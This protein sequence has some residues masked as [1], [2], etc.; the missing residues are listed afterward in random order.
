MWGQR[1]KNLYSNCQK[2]AE[3]L[4][5]TVLTNGVWIWAIRIVMWICWRF[6]VHFVYQRTNWACFSINA[7]ILTS[8][9]GSAR[10]VSTQQKRWCWNIQIIPTTSFQ[11]S[12]DSLVALIFTESSRQ[13]KAVL[14]QNG[15]TSTLQMQHKMTQI[16]HNHHFVKYQRKSK[17]FIEKQP[18]RCRIPT[19]ATPF[20]YE[21]DTC[22]VKNCTFFRNNSLYLQH[23]GNNRNHAKDRISPDH[24]RGV[25]TH[26]RYYL[27][28]CHDTWV[29]DVSW[30]SLE[31]SL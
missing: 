19:N 22:T 29:Q 23:E 8:E 12:V 10:Y 4:S 9:Y 28:I 26:I 17:I 15:E 16:E 21:C 7:C 6:L 31:G 24:H 20:W 13:K 1:R 14:L 2:N 11:P 3:T 27:G 18:K 5:K 30:E 25:C